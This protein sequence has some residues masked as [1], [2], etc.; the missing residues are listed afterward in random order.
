MARQ[1]QT[2]GMIGIG[3]LGL[4]VAVNLM[5]AGF[6]VVGFRRHGREEFVRQ[7]GKALESPAEVARAATVVLLC[8]PNESAAL[9]VLEGRDGILPALTADHTVVEMGTYRKAFKLEQAAKLTATGA[10][11]LEAEISG[12]PPMVVSRKAAIYAGGDPQVFQACLPVLEAITPSVFHLGE[13]GSAVA[14]KLI[15][16]YL[17]SIHTLAAAEAMNLGARAGFDPQLV[18]EVIQK[19]AG[20]SAM[21][22]VRAPLMAA[23]KFSP[24]PGPFNTLEKYLK[25]GRAMADELGCATP[26]FS[27]S[28]PYFERALADGM[29]SEDIAAV[30][31]LIEADSR[32]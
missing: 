12:S 11:V 2:V 29:G 32:P 7:G 27:V 14:M 24:A 15:A 10:R 22:G 13:Y 9:D 17:L 21:F 23:R 19:G 1:N 4:P 5:Q 25:L 18:A 3:Q 31:K 20:G 26:L 16:N 6:P 28:T 8:L 30:I